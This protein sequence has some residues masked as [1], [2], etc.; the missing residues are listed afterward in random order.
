MFSNSAEL[1]KNFAPMNPKLSFPLS[2]LA[3]RPGCPPVA[4]KLLLL[5]ASALSAP[6]GQAQFTPADRG[7]T[8]L[9]DGVAT[10]FS[11]YVFY[12]NN[13]SFILNGARVSNDWTRIGSWDGNSSNLMVVSGSG[14]ILFQTGTNANKDH[15]MVGA[16]NAVDNRAFITNGGTVYARR[17]YVGA[18]GAKRSLMVI[19][20]GGSFTNFATTSA[21]GSGAGSDQNQLIVTNGG[22]FVQLGGNF[23]LGNSGSSNTILAVGGGF[24]QIASSLWLGDG[25]SGG[26]DNA[27]IMTNGGI[28]GIANTTGSSYLGLN[29]GNVRNMILVSGAGSVF[30]NMNALLQIGV[31]G[32]DNRVIV[33][34][35]GFMISR[36]NTVGLLASASGNSIQVLNCG[37]L[38]TSALVISNA[39]NAITNSG[40]VFLFDVGSPKI[41]PLNGS[42]IVVTNGTIGFFGITTAD[43]MGSLGSNEIANITFQGAN[44]F[45]LDSAANTAAASPQDYAFAADLS[46]N[47]YAGLELINGNTSWK[48]AWLSFGSSGSMLV[49]NTAASIQ[50]VLTNAGVITV[51]RA[52]ATFASNVILAAGGAFHAVGGNLT[53]I[54]SRGLTIDAGGSFVAEGGA[55][56]VEGV[57]TNAGSIGVTNA[58]VVFQNA[59]VNQGAY[60]SDPS[61]NAFNGVFTVGPTGYVSAAA[62]DLYAFG[63]DFVLQSTNRA[64]FNMAQAKIVFATNG[65]GL[66]TTTAKHTLNLT[67]SGALD[68]GSNWISHLQLQTNFALGTLTIALSN[69]VTL[70]GVQS[71][72]ATNALYLGTLDLSAWDTSAAGLTNTLLGALALPN[73][74]LYYDRDDPGNAY[75]GGATYGLWSGGGLL[76]PIPEPTTLWAGAA[77]LALLAFLRRRA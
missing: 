77:G 68:L 34:D 31:G 28:V 11:E 4:W 16:G 38:K 7:A 51:T 59:V 62:G 21:V 47:H 42:A 33:R 58:S 39:N 32:A 52:K 14:S 13:T 20:S 57:I 65:Y 1:L 25:G 6:S 76:I 15:F 22:S 5:I 26:T 73:V 30:S 72:G 56:R 36:T 55:S 37:I 23:G 46:P 60:V 10:N 61:T 49:S 50:G 2:R 67:N 54:F 70:T 74:N 69:Q 63:S 75:L 27:L 29:A 71:G 17:I 8:N 53:N 44:I 66:A 19:G 48:S 45:R 64:A 43:V 12:T 35:G 9:F 40:G 41:A 18:N 3:H 24:F